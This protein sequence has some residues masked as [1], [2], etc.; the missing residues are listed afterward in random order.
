M[1]RCLDPWQ[2]LVHL[3]E[4]VFNEFRGIPNRNVRQQIEV[5]GHAGELVEVINC[6]RTDDLLCRRDGAH[7]D[8]IGCS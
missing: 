1:K 7:G 6:L 2:L 4:T 5:D 8:E 3:R